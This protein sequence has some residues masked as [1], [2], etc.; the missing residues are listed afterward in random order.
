MDH[1]AQLKERFLN[2]TARDKTKDHKEFLR[3][4]RKKRK[5]EE[6]LLDYYERFEKLYYS[7]KEHGFLPPSGVPREKTGIEKS[8]KPQSVAVRVVARHQQWQQI[9][10]S[11]VVGA[12]RDQLPEEYSQFFSHPDVEYLLN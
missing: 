5:S 10:E 3:K 7:I 11:I 12:N 2:N 1:E 4:F 6:D 9:R 8:W